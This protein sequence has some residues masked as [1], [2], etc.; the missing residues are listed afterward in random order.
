[1]FVACHTY[2]TEEGVRRA[3]NAG[4]RTIEHAAP[5]DESMGKAFY[6]DTYYVPT[7]VAAVDD[8]GI[9]KLFGKNNIKEDILQIVAKINQ[10]EN[11]FRYQTPASIE[12][13]FNILL[14]IL[15]YSI[16]TDQ[17]LCIGSD[18]GCKGTDFSSAIREILLLSALGFSN[19]QVLKY[20]ITN[21]CKALGL[22]NRGKIKENFVADLVI[23]E[24]NP[25]LDITTLLH[26]IA[27]VCQ[28]NLINLDKFEYKK[29]YS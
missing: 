27:V 14:N 29:Y 8:C 17:L 28:G 24:H 7:F 12:E 6:P 2:P 19:S 5:F 22:N 23:L 21:P 18:A 4:V 25:I 9:S 3:L 26:N 20:A 1:M 13:W 10:K 15:P 16:K 11:N